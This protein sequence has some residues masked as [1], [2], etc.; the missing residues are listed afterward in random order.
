MASKDFERSISTAPT[1]SLLSLT[2]LPFL[3]ERQQCMFGTETLYRA[4]LV[5]GH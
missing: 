2:L 1:Y 4:T 3:N 5:R